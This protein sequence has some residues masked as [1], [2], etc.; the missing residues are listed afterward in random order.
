MQVFP[1]ASKYFPP[2]KTF[3]KYHLW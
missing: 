2:K 1:H 3:T